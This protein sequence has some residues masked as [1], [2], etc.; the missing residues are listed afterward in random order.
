MP[1]TGTIE[2]GSSWLAVLSMTGILGFIPFGIII[3][4]SVKRVWSKRRTNIEA[5]LYLGLIVFLSI[6]MLVEG[7]ILAGGSVLCFIAW[8]IISCC[9]EIDSYENNS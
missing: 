1:S 7:F 4:K 2:T 5:C 8:I 3:Y 6:H 9:Y